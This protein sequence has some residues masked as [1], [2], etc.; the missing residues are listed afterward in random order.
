MSSKGRPED[1]DSIEEND[2]G[3]RFEFLLRQAEY[4]HFMINTDRNKVS[5]TP[6]KPKAGRPKKKLDDS[7][8]PGE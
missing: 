1:F 4:K 2:R 7:G 8:E 6:V 3:K 5:A